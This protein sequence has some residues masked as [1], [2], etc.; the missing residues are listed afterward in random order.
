MNTGT[1]IRLPNADKWR[2]IQMTE[3]KY[4]KDLPP[5]NVAGV[6]SEVHIV[7]PGRASRELRK[8]AVPLVAQAVLR[9]HGLSPCSICERGDACGRA[10]FLANGSR[11]YIDHDYLE[12]STAVSSSTREVVAALKAGDILI[13]QAVD[14]V[15]RAL[16][17]VARLTAVRNTCDH[18]GHSYAAHVNVS[19]TRAAFDRLMQDEGD[20]LHETI[21]PLLVSL[22]LVCGAGRAGSDK[23]EDVFQISEKAD[24]IET[25]RGPQ[26][27]ANRPLLNTR[28]EP[29]AD[30]RRHARLH[31]ICLDANRLQTPEFLKVGILRLFCAAMDLG[32]PTVAMPLTEPIRAMHSISRS[33]FKP[34]RLATGQTI[35][36]LGIQEL[37]LNCMRKRSNELGERV[38][39]VLDILDRWEGVLATL[40][41]GYL[42]LVGVLDW[43]TKF[44]CLEVARRDAKARWSDPRLAWMDIRYHAL[45]PQDG[46]VAI[47]PAQADRGKMVSDAE[48]A[49]LVARP[50]GGGRDALRVG[51][52]RHFADEIDLCEWHWMSGKDG[53][54]YLLPDPTTEPG[55]VDLASMPSLAKAAEALGLPIA[56][57]DPSGPFPMDSPSGL[58][59][60]QHDGGGRPELPGESPQVDAEQTTEGTS[61]ADVPPKLY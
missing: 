10:E 31:L 13:Q 49:A 11:C 54:C 60:C 3:N 18:R 44:A 53:T 59:A 4:S 55:H 19:M 47:V 23:G 37:F 9:R 24:Y 26:T 17:S 36:A 42:E 50:P 15:N 22:P 61:S 29:L 1:T 40:G 16:P 56:R 33:P 25:E 45:T 52:L 38:P 46:R 57:I 12:Y 20:L 7:A 14:E 35:T 30:T 43:V 5:H 39:D 34:V 41:R 32:I 51:L 6:E 27:T 28:D 8:Q 2:Q 48:I 21:A 58:P